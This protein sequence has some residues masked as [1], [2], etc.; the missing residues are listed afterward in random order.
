MS[1]LFGT[2]A[3][4]VQVIML[5]SSQRI[6][7]RLT[8]LVV[9]ATLAACTQA[10]DVATAVGFHGD[11]LAAKATAGPRVT[12]ANPPYGQ[13]GETT[14]LVKIFG[15]GFAP[16]PQ[17]AWERDGVP[18]PK[19]TVH[20]AVAV[21][22]SEI[23]A[24][25]SI[26]SD[27]TLDL[28]DIAVTVAGK[29]G[30]GTEM[31]EVTQA[32][33]IGTLGGNS[34]AR[35]ANDLGYVVG[36]SLDASNSQRAFV[37]TPET[38]M[39]DLGPVDAYEIDEAG[40]TVVGSSANGAA[41]WN[42]NGSTWERLMLPTDP[43][44]VSSRALAVAS[45]IDGVARMVVGWEEYPLKRSP[46]HRPRI[47]RRATPT[48]PWE[49]D[50]LRLP[51][52][53]AGVNGVNTVTSSGQV[54]GSATDGNVSQPVFWDSAGTP[55]LLPKVGSSA[56]TMNRAATIAAGQSDGTAAY[57]VATVSGSGARAWAGPFILPG[58]CGRAVGV[59]DA[60]NIA[61]TGCPGSSGRTT[62]G[63][64]KPPYTELTLLGGLG[65]RNDGAAADGISPNGMVVGGARVAGV[66]VGAVWRLLAQ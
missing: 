32:E 19:I 65:D 45:G 50:T 33:S 8:Q 2:Y 40:V 20:E 64:W 60:E 22:S 53:Y 28:Y 41:V 6:T 15:S 4:H 61:G 43:T 21:S 17:V 1:A 18:D 63:I 37:W 29:K 56:H 11:G 26:A 7:S 39:R 30:I 24:T 47:W 49:R 16:N 9:A 59:D 66:R 54:L 35:D 52:P 36:Y 5:P 57:W 46:R 58:G 51:S 12:S 42:W 27:A 3:S 38:G 34:L 14:K 62:P 48:S 44:A 13:Q 55:T 31:F 10:G 25:I 23:H